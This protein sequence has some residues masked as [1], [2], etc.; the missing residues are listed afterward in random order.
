MCVE[1]PPTQTQNIANNVYIGV[2][3][4]PPKHD[5]IKYI[6]L[7]YLVLV[8]LGYSTGGHRERECGECKQ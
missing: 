2:F 6:R 7:D 1:L 5:S 3:I 4:R 8:H